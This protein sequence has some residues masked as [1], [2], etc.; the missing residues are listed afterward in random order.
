MLLNILD[1][2]L[3]VEPKGYSMLEAGRPWS[4]WESSDVLFNSDY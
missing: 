3:H 2:S 1:G 4:W